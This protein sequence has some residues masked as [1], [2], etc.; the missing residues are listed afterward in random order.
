MK[1]IHALRSIMTLVLTGVL[2]LVATTYI[3][4]LNDTL[5]YPFKTG[6]DALVNGVTWEGPKTNNDYWQYFQ[7]SFDASTVDFRDVD[8]V[9]IQYRADVATPGITVG[10]LENGDRYSTGAGAADGK[11]VYFMN[12]NGLVEQ[13]GVVQYGAIWVPEG[14]Q[15]ALLIPMSSLGWQWNNAGSDLSKVSSFFITS[16]SLHNNNY[17]LSIGEIGFIKGDLETGEFTKI[18]DLS[19]QSKFNKYYFDSAVDTKLTV[20]KA[21]YP[22]ET[23]T[24]SFNGG[25]KWSNILTSPSE[26]DTW[27]TLFLNFN[28]PVDLTSAKYLAIQYRADKGTPGITYGFETGDARYATV[29]DG[30]PIYFMELDG[31]MNKLTDVLYA[32]VNVTE[33]KTGLL[34]IPMDAFVYQF[35]GASNTLATAKNLLLTTNS[36]YNIN[37]ALS[38]GEVGYFDGVIGDANTNYHKLEI[39]SLYNALPLDSTLE[40]I[41]AS[42]YPLETGDKA[43]NGGMSWIAPA[44]SSAADSWEALFINFK[45]PQDLTVASYL[46]V[47][48]RSDAGMPGLTWGVENAGTRYSTMVDGNKIYFMNEQGVVEEVSETLYSA[49]SVPQG[50]TG[51][52]LLPMSALTYQFG[53]IQNTLLDVNNV[54]LT[55]NSLYNWNFKVSVGQVGYFDGEIGD[56]NTTYHPIEIDT[57]FNASSKFEMELIDVTDFVMPESMAYPFRSGEEAFKNG[58]IWSAPATPNSEDDFQT[59]SIT[60]DNPANFTDATYLAVQMGNPSG[61]PGLTYEIQN[62]QNSLSIAAVEDGTKV[63]YIKEDG[64][65][66]VASIIQYSAITT[67]IPVGTLLIP[68]EAFDWVN[69]GA[70]KDLTEMTKLVISTN[71]KYNYNY[72]FTIGEIGIYKGQ[73]GSESLSFTKLFDLSEPKNASFAI[74]GSKTNEA[75][76]IDTFKERTEYGDTII[77][78]T[79]TGKN[80]SNFGI[81]TGGSY[82]DVKMT[83]DSYGDTAVQVKATGSNPVGDSYTAIDI[84]PTGGFSWANFAGITFWARNDSDREVSFNVEIDNKIVSSGLSDRFNIKQGHRFYLYDVNTGK[85]SIYMT[86]PVA[87]LPVGFEGWVRIP[88]NAFARADWSNN[89]VTKAQ[90]MAEGTMVTYLAITIHS[91]T[92]LDMP[93]SL[94][95]FGAYMVDPSFTSS[96]VL[97]NDNRFSIPQLMDLEG[98]AK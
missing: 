85:T 81:W 43:F 37:F 4:A 44:N 61:M 79:A 39:S 23:G 40:V 67:N 63:Y 3:Y 14:K 94:N 32:A 89:G 26:N 1:K 47:Q 28:N 53:D 11:P 5:V 13:L 10:L 7:A 38:I 66:K 34:L 54:L 88:F 57:Y 92:Y 90:F 45:E 51:L 35:G 98:G 80:P 19:I 22:H 58:K 42:D 64:S 18:L 29:L 65:I 33:G 16:N 48:F 97:P 74:A 31:S 59:L 71:R 87:T 72:Q 56:E 41:D 77:S 46:A 21:E 60:F 75:T 83:T 12:E 9:A 20:V 36:K 17:T 6:D 78:F 2:A 30:K 96:F 25:H 62:G 68:M 50:K 49:V 55:T 8:Y 86:K 91:T 93:F 73:I 15:G 69:E 27:Q 95:K 52:L 84:A 70:S 24:T 82:G 76:L